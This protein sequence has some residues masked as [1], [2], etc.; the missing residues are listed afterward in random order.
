MR[1]TVIATGFDHPNAEQQSPP[2]RAAEEPGSAS[3]APLFGKEEKPSYDADE[4]VLDIPSF[5]KDR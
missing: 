1:V 5:L 2:P 3:S 4:E